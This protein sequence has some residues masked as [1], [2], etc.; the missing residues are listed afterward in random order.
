MIDTTTF[1][2][3]GTTAG[4]GVS[5]S[6][7]GYEGVNTINRTAIQILNDRLVETPHAPEHL[8]VPFKSEV[9]GIASI[10]DYF[11]DISNL[12]KYRIATHG[13]N[14]GID[15]QETINELK[16]FKN[17]SFK[18]I[19]WEDFLFRLKYPLDV[20]MAFRDGFWTVY[21]EELEILAIAPDL[22]QCKKD[23]QEEF[24]ILWEEYVNAPDNELSLDG[25]KLKYKLRE[26][27]EGVVGED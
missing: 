14:Y 27:V 15:P 6:Q 12:Q 23:F 10:L 16:K 17:F 18:K 21:D 7:R 11:Y 4:F 5:L 19:G 1:E 22:E 25:Q 8:S 2:L 24:C 26:V 9:I 3:K 20:M 13:S